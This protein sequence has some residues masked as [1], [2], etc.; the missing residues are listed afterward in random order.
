MTVNK[1]TAKFMSEH[2]GKKFYFC[3]EGCKKRFDEDP[4]KYMKH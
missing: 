3:S 2:M 1:E 4:M